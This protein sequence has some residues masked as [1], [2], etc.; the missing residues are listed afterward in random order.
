VGIVFSLGIKLIVIKIR[1]IVRENKGRDKFECELVGRH[2][3][4]LNLFILR[5]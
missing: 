2:F 5:E 3:L 4:T 1:E